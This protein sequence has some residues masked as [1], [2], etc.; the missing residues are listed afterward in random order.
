[1]LMITQIEDSICY[2]VNSEQ[3]TS[4]E[5]IICKDDNDRIIKRKRREKDKQKFVSYAFSQF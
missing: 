3:F 5:F 4:E 2:T 1:M